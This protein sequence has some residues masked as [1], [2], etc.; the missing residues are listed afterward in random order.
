[1]SPQISKSKEV[2]LEATT[3]MKKCEDT[4]ISCYTHQ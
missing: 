2:F 3:T 4:V 1:M